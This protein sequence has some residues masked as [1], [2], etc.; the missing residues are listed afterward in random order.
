MKVSEAQWPSVTSQGGIKD[1]LNNRGSKTG[2]KIKTSCSLWS[3]L[4]G[5]GHFD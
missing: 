5:H 3:F 1:F 4:T 2:G